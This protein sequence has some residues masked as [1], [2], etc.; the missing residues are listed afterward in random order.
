M[1]ITR[2]KDGLIT[3][4]VDASGTTSITY[5]PSTWVKAVTNGANKT[6]TYQ[7]NGVGKVTKLTTPGNLNFTYSYNARNQLSSI[8]NPAGKTIS[9]TYDNGGRRTKVSRSG[10]Y[11]EYVYNAR[12]WVYYVKNK[13]SSGNIKYQVKYYWD[14]MGNVTKKAEWFEGTSGYYW[15]YYSLDGVYRLTREARKYY[16]SSTYDYDYRWYYDAVGN[17]T[18]EQDLVAGWTRYYTYDNADKLTK[19]GTSSGG[20]QLATFGY[21][22]NGNMTSVSGS[23]FGSKTLT[24]DDENRL[25]Q[26]TYGGVTDKYY[27]DWQGRRYRAKLNGTYYRYVYN[28]DRVLEETNDSGSVL[29]RYTTESG[30]YYAPL[31]HIWR[32]GN[33]SRY[34]MYD[35]IGTSR[36][37]VNDSATITDTYQLDAWG[38]QIASSGSTQN[39]YKYACPPAV[40]R[41]A[42]WGYPPSPRLWRTGITDPSGDDIMER[43]L[44]S[45]GRVVLDRDPGPQGL[46]VGRSW[47][48]LCRGTRRGH[49]L[50]TMPTR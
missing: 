3:Q 44:L 35:G 23:L 12:D 24:Y 11:I 47:G 17:R 38:H 5:Y 26:I 29:A 36:G 6:V 31:Q 20:S 37:L 16:T 33:I 32:S 45:L 18:K 19:I 7:Y 13:D 39:P 27:Y 4:V 43:P 21:D 30:S 22:S 15:T 34:P 2:D 42:A 25:K 41:G 10:G 1:K 50:T 48:G 9:Y 46:G 49:T 14:N 28:G 40:W 8:T